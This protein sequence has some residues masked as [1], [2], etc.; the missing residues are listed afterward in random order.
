MDRTRNEDITIELGIFA[1]NLKD[2][3][4]RETDVT[5]PKNECR[6]N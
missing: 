2:Q 3:E 6:A 1:L 4:N 5:S